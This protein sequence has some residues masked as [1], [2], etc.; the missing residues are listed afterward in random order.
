MTNNIVLF[1][2]EEAV[3]VIVDGFNRA[4]EALSEIQIR[5]DQIR[6]SVRIRII[7]AGT[8]VYYYLE[9]AVIT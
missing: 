3:S 6:E 7:I 2:P 9:S 1:S 5:V 8:T 4:S